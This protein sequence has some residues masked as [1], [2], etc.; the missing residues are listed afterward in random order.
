MP[1]VSYDIILHAPMISSSDICVEIY[2]VTEEPQNC[3][4]GLSA[5]MTSYLHNHEVKSR[6]LNFIWKL[7]C[8]FSFMLTFVVM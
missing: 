5:Q 2:D 4:H 8:M 6:D 3:S 7:R 1:L